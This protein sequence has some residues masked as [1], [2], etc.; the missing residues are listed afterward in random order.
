MTDRTTTNP[1]AT[2]Y[3]FY[4]PE[5]HRNIREIDD[6][7]NTL[8]WTFGGATERKATGHYFNGREIETESIV[9]VEVVVTQETGEGTKDIM[10]AQTQ[11][12]TDELHAAGEKDVWVEASYVAVGAL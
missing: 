9:T 10:L 11:R 12:I 8:I 3:T 1:P 6:A 2:K 7:I 4:I 5:Q